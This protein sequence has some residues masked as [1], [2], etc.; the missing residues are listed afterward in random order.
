MTHDEWFTKYYR[1]DRLSEER[2]GIKGF[3]QIVRASHKRDLETTGFDLISRHESTTGET[4]WFPYNP[5]EL[6]RAK[7]LDLFQ[8][9]V[10]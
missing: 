6:K 10:G 8:K 5:Y 3:E 1:P 2:S 7:Q 9:A 4:V